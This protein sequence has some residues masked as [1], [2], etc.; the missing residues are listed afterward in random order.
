MKKVHC[1][2]CWCVLKTDECLANS[3]D[4]FRCHRISDLACTVC[5]G[6]SIPIIVSV[7]MISGVQQGDSTRRLKRSLPICL[8]ATLHL[9]CSSEYP[10]NYQYFQQ[11][12]EEDNKDIEE[13]WW[14]PQQC[15]LHAE[16][17]IFS[18][19]QFIGASEIE[20]TRKSSTQT[21]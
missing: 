15:L 19:L 20:L 18:I 3:V 9:N 12:I 14:S 11:I 2:T 16:I 21:C 4:Q 7:I 6:L 10:V 1:T 8:S 13:R 5:S 17:N